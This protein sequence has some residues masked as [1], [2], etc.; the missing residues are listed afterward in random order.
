M[1]ALNMT[2][3]VGREAPGLS[4]GRQPGKSPV[5]HK[6]G[7][8]PSDLALEIEAGDA[9]GF[10]PSKACLRDQFSPACPAQVAPCRLGG[11][12]RAD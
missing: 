12:R 2:S 3:P 11:L 9:V 7:K 10:H 5:M 4:H 1:E 6:T 8:L